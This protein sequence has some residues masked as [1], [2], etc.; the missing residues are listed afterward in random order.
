L[1]FLPQKFSGVHKFSG[2]EIKQEL[3]DWEGGISF[4]DHS[5]D[6]ILEHSSNHL[7]WYV[8]HPD[9]AFRLFAR[10]E[11]FQFSTDLPYMDQ[12]D[13]AIKYKD[14]AKIEWLPS[15]TKQQQPAISYKYLLISVVLFF[16]LGA[17]VQERPFVLLWIILGLQSGLLWSIYFRRKYR[18]NILFVYNDNG[19][20]A[21]LLFSVAGADKSDCIRFFKQHAANRFFIVGKN[22]NLVR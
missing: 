3:G 15:V 12:G 4:S 2:E 16:L 8:P 13:Y 22:E 9:K 20:Q 17:T 7:E 5:I 14:L 11:G 10:P 21:E 19:K 18:H 6:L 1:L